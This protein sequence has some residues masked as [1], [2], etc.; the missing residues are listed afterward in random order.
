M[1]LKLNPVPDFTI[2]GT[3]ASQTVQVGGGTSYTTTISAQ[4]PFAGVVTLSA[5]GLP[6]GASATF[7]PPTVT[8][9]GT[10]TLGV[11]TSL[12]TP[13]GSYPLTITGT[14][15]SLTHT[16]GV[17]LVVSDFGVSVTPASQTVVAG[18]NTTYT[19][20]VSIQNGFSGTAALSVSGLPSGATGTFNPTGITGAGTSTLTVTTSTSTP[21]GT[22]TLTVTGTSGTL[23]HSTTATLVVTSS[24]SSGLA[25]DA[26]VSADKNTSSTSAVSPVFSTT[27]A[28]ELLL[29]F[30]SAD[31]SSVGSQSVTG[32]AGGGLTWVLV[33]RAAG[34]PGDAE[35]WRAFA[36]APLTN[37][38]VTATLSQSAASSI[39]VLSFSGVDTTGVNGA[40]AVGASMATSSAT[41]A[42]SVALITTRNNSWV[43]AVGTDWH[44]P[45]LA[46]LGRT[47][48]WS[49]R[50]SRPSTAPTGCSGK[51]Q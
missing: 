13:P 45:L 14:S 3:P 46:P 19:T 44:T 39:T 1:T 9:S 21:V 25:I 34:Q 48:P 36:S 24:T 2:A 32:I 26:N 12:S 18:G 31:S 11:T 17:T 8:G 28:N 51:M 5:S 10:S 4:G 6:T 16:A 41:G 15:G 7:T 22:S 35:I 37:A 38:T 29:A 20:T 27:A 42:P 40:G 50:C 23:V 33:K 43:F 49:T 30:V 47:R